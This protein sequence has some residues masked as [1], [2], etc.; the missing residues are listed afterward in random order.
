RLAGAA[1]SGRGIVVSGES[2]GMEAGALLA[3][4]R[5]PD[6]L[7]RADDAAREH[8]IG[9]VGARTAFLPRR[10][11]ANR[12]A[13]EKLRGIDAEEQRDQQ[14]RHQ[15]QTATAEY[16]PG[17]AKTAEAAA[18]VLAPAVL[19]IVRGAKIIKTHGKSS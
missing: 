5:R 6:I 9:I 19:H 18:I 12:P 8:V 3:Q 15:A 10:R 17:S 7:R 16:H 2:G 11:L 4:Q 1:A 13:I 14:H